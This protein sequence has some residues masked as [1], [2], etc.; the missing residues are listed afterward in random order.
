MPGWC[1]VRLVAA[2]TPADVTKGKE[3]ELTEG[4]SIGVDGLWLPQHRR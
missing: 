3:V 2:E 4:L 1:S